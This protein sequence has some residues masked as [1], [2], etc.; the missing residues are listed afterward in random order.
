MPNRWVD[1]VKNYS[2][3]NNISYTCAMCEIKNK[4]LYK[5]LKKEEP[6]PVEKRITIKTKKQKEK[7]QSKAPEFSKQ[8][9]YIKLIIEYVDNYNLA[10]LKNI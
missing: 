1:F 5:P 6:K 7:E 9:K 4:G 10:E 2:K 8:E 3:E